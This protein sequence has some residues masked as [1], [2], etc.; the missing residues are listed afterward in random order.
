MA[1]RMK[2]F[3]KAMTAALDGPSKKKIKIEKHNFNVD[4]ANITRVGNKIVVVGNADGKNISHRLKFRPDDQV[5]YAFEVV[6]GQVKNLDIRVRKGSDKTIK[7]I[8]KVVKV[9]KLALEVKESIDQQQKADGAVVANDAANDAAFQETKRLLD[10]SW[11]GEARF[12]IANIALRASKS[13]QL[14]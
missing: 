13:K 12:M 5:D 11:R 7:L 4:M 1:V 2:D 9:I 6:G 14:T 3:E 8:K 10:G